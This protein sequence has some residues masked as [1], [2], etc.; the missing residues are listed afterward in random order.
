MT[1]RGYTARM[2]RCAGGNFGIRARC[3]DG[4]G[5]ALL[6]FGGGGMVPLVAS[7]REAFESILDLLRRG[8]Q[9]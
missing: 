9:V 5:L 3:D 1:V 2:T 4:G 7:R 8:T 6:I